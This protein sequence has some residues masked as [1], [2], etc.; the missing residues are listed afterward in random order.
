M[1]FSAFVAAALGAYLV[2]GCAST[3]SPLYKTS[4]TVSDSGI[5]GAWVG[6]DNDNRSIVHIE[7]GQH[8]FYEVTVHD[9]KSGDDSV[10]DAHLVK[11]SNE[12]FADLLLVE[13][14]HAGQSI[15]LPPGAV[16]LHEIVEYR[17]KGDNLAISVIDGDAFG[18]AAKQP[19][20]PLQFRD[21][22]VGTASEVGG[23]TVILSTTDELRRYFSAHPTDIFGKPTVL[24]RQP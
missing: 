10:Y 21:T 3:V 9:L 4:D 20:F 12:S 18:K 23:D 22:K 13:Y 11:L 17:L 16:A 7:V 15:D 6:G 2:T 8:G 14:R 1:R 24:K 19:E 5:V